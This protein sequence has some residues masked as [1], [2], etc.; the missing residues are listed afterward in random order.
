MSE[1][2]FADILF[3][4]QLS[5]ANLQLAHAASSIIIILW[6]GTVRMNEIPFPDLI[7]IVNKWNELK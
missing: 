3:G 5:L 1:N 2:E 6:I 4:E 7:K